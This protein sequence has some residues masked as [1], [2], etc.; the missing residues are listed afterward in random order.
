[1]ADMNS[2]YP[3]SFHRKLLAALLCLSATVMAEAHAGDV[4]QARAAFMAHYSALDAARAEPFSDAAEQALLT[5][6]PLT[7]WLAALRL[8]NALS[9]NEP[10]AEGQAVEFLDA[11]GEAPHARDLRRALLKFQA[12]R[13]DWASLVSQYREAAAN[14]ESRCLYAVAR[15]QLDD[16]AGLV[17]ELAGRWIAADGDLHQACAPA[18]AWLQN[19]RE[20]T[21]DL[22]AQRI[23]A[24]LLDGDVRRAKPLLARLPESRRAPLQAWAKLLEDR[25][26]AFGELAEGPPLALDAEGLAD[27]FLR[28]AKKEPERAQDLLPAII[29]RQQLPQSTADLLTRN[30]ALAYAWTRDPR[31]LALFQQV[32]A[33]ALD[34]RGYEWRVRAALWSGDWGSALAWLNALPPVLAQQQRW[35]YWRARALVATGHA[36]EGRPLLQ[37]LAQ[38]FD[39]FGLFAAWQLGQAYA[40]PDHPIAVTTAVRAEL[41][42]NDALERAHEAYLLGLTSIAALEW[43]AALNSVAEPARPALITEAA[44]WGWYAQ[45]ITSATELHV[46]DDAHALFPRPW[47]ALVA[48]AAERSGIAETWIYSVMRRESA[49][50][51]DAASGAGALG[52]LQMLPGTAAIT[53]HKNGLP[54]PSRG[55]LIR[56]EINLPLGALHLAEMQERFGGNWLFTLAAYNAGPNALLRWLPP[57]TM[58]ADV[59]MENIPFNET[60][61]YVQRILL[62]AAVYQWLQ[63][64]KPV[65]AEAWLADIEAGS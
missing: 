24:R 1:M 50:R 64:G 42:R 58:P 21:G 29:S 62:H 43:R 34:E 40:P 60:R 35:R 28:F 51:A 41:G 53:A 7:P 10:G 38:E 54:K 22:L 2:S 63:T 45:A 27:A 6:Y 57:Q 44:N 59:W 61:N 48:G 37:A 13:N 26:E 33:A 55:D 5:S 47:P 18:I 4:E 31:A 46:F 39:S 15:I 9:G 20:L 8:R 65:R 52:L 3:P 16:T 56:P 25:E 14:E 32:P 49:F 36:E 23:R 17:R 30:L 11:A 12:G 19:Q